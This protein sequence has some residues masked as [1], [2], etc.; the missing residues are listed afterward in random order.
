[1]QGADT[2]DRVIYL[3][4]FAKLLF[5]A[6]RLGFMVLPE[7][8][9]P[10][11]ATVLSITGQF[12]PL[13]LQ[14]ALADFIDEGHMSMHLKR[15]RR[16]YASRRQAFRNHAQ[17]ELGEWMTLRPSDAGIQFVGEL[18]SGLSDVAI[19]AA[20]RRRGLNISPLSMQYRHSKAAPGLVLG[21]AAINEANM[22]AAFQSLKLAFVEATRPVGG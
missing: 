1:M 6:L 7:F 20:A 18:R 4:T 9:L 21:Y 12:A 14:A 11:I 22:P 8:L 16:I 15:M 3:G 5:P 10:D 2:S 13:L 17:R 19:A